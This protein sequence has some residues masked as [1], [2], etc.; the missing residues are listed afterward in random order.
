M[1]D[2]MRPIRSAPGGYEQGFFIVFIF[3]LTVS[4]FFSFGPEENTDQCHEIRSNARMKFCD[5]PFI[6]LPL[7][8]RRKHSRFRN[9]PRLNWKVMTPRLQLSRKAAMSVF[10]F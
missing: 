6:L 5:T 3:F 7:Y 9:F 2:L 8:R 4:W 1:L 10:C